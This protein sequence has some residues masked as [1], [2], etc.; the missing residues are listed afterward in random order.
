MASRL[1]ISE[2]RPDSPESEESRAI[3]QGGAPRRTDGRGAVRRGVPDAPREGPGRSYTGGAVPGAVQHPVPSPCCTALGT[4]RG[5]GQLLAGTS[6][7]PRL[8]CGRA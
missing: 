7:G 6:P 4:P 1:A 5:A 3:P 2:S 8:N